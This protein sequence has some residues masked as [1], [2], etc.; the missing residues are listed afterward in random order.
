M[1]LTVKENFPRGIFLTNTATKYFRHKESGCSFTS[2]DSYAD[3]SRVSPLTWWKTRCK[4]SVDQRTIGLKILFWFGFFGVFWWNN[5]ANYFVVCLVVQDFTALG[6]RF[7]KCH[8][9]QLLEFSQL[10]RLD[11]PGRIF[12]QRSCKSVL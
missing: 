9:M 1:L 11:F 2:K 5:G 7:V 8:V 4:V 3:K 12:H 10:V 6:V